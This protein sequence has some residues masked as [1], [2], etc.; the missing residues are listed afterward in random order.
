MFV[1]SQNPSRVFFERMELTLLQDLTEPC[2]K[3]SLP[4]PPGGVFQWG[5]GTHSKCKICKTG[6]NIAAHAW[7]NNH[8]ID[9]NKGRIID[10]DI[11]R[12][13]KTLESWHN[14]NTNDADNNSKPLLKQY[15]ILLECQ[16]RSGV[17]MKEK[18]E[19]FSFTFDSAHVRYGV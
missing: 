12:I 10:K 17:L 16:V 13:R 4:P 11:F 8:S 15:S 18:K 2:N 5:K 3:N 19:F 14:A 1:V 6:S 9:F 7:H